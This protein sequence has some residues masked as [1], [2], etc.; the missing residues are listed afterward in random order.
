MPVPRRRSTAL[1]RRGTWVKATACTAEGW[2]DS[3]AEQMPVSVFQMQMSAVP[4]S[5]RPAAAD[6]SSAPLLL[7]AIV[8]M[9]C[10]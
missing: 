4:E 5:S 9:R 7:T 3:T 2:Y 6:A 1:L 8:E 10:G